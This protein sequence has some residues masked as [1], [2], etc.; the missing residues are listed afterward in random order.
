MD[1][2][3]ATGPGDNFCNTDCKGN[4]YTATDCMLAT[5]RLHFDLHCSLSLSL[6]VLFFPLVLSPSFL[7]HCRVESKPILSKP[8]SSKRIHLLIK[9]RLEN[10][11]RQTFKRIENLIPSLFPRYTYP[12]SHKIREVFIPILLPCNSILA[13]RLLLTRADNHL[14]RYF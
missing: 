11:N 4:L 13:F 8:L 2:L 10:T 3:L 5:M 6:S 1:F 14:W 9:I 12:L 7:S